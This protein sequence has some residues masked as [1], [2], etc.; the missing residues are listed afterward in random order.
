VDLA[1]EAARKALTRNKG[2]D[3]ARAPSAVRAKYLRAIAAKVPFCRAPI[4]CLVF[5]AFSMFLSLDRTI[6]II[7]TR[8]VSVF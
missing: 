2:R 3:W 7:F 1:V 5:T 6:R 8:I 4:P